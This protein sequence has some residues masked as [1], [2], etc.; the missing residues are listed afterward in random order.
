MCERVTFPVSFVI[1]A[2]FRVM[3]L[4]ELHVRWPFLFS[5]SL[6]DNL[7]HLSWRKTCYCARRCR[8]LNCFCFSALNVITRVWGFIWWWSGAVIFRPQQR[9]R[10]SLV[11]PFSDPRGATNTE[12]TNV[13]YLHVT[14][15]CCFMN[16]VWLCGTFRV[17]LGPVETQS[18]SSCWIS[19]ALGALGPMKY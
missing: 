13:I 12:G 18:V 2:W 17:A 9:R 19:A 11:S 1:H 6:S 8:C 7:K 4:C 3:K 5:F 15:S 14:S 10:F 16:L